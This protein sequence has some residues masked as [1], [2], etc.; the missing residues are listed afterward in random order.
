MKKILLRLF[1][2]VSVLSFSAEKLV[3][4]ESTRMDNKGICYRRRNTIYRYSR[5]L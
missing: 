3:K 5:K 1:L 4:I 2:L